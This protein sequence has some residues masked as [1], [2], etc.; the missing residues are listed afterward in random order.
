MILPPL[1]FD[2]VS[3]TFSFSELEEAPECSL[4]TKATELRWKLRDFGDLAA[5]DRVMQ[6]GLVKASDTLREAIADRQNHQRALADAEAKAALAS[7]E[8]EAVFA[9]FHSVA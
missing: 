6:R 9:H 4:L 8:L 3:A 2:K 7:A 1:R 5:C